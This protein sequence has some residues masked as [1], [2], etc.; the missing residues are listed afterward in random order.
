MDQKSNELNA[1]VIDQ[2]HTSV[3]SIE[4][5]FLSKLNR[6]LFS[7]DYAKFE[8]RI[9]RAAHYLATNWEFFIIDRMNAGFFGLEQTGRILPMKWKSFMIWPGCKNSCWARKAAISWI[10][11]GSSDFSKDGPSHPGF[12]KPSVLGH[13]LIV[14]MLLYL[15]S[16]EIGAGGKRIYNNF[17]AG[18]F[19][20]L[21]EVL[22]RDIVSPVKRSVAGLEELIKT[23]EQEQFGRKS[24]HAAPGLAAGNALFPGR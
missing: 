22:T 19:H 18:L 23:I 4:G 16:L 8:K 20:D 13:M 11:W 14:A 1:W 17:F 24:C 2:I 21:P 3:A 9:L 7:L 5:N 12:R 6:Y 10:W 15:F